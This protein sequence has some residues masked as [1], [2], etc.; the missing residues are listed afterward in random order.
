MRKTELPTYIADLRV[1]PFD[2]DLNHS[3]DEVAT[4][5]DAWFDAK[6]SLE[7]LPEPGRRATLGGDV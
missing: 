3:V 7:Q 1:G 5:V 6:V 2:E 4:V